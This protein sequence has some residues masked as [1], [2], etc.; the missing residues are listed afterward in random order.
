MSGVFRERGNAGHTGRNGGER[1]SS[2]PN[3]AWASG[4]LQSGSRVE[5]VGGK[6]LKEYIIG[7]G[8]FLL[9]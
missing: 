5:S 6:L 2:T 4:N 9:N 1:L 3:A 8:E 7:K